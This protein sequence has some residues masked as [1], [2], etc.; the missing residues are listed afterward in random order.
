MLLFPFSYSQRAAHNLPLKAEVLSLCVY[1]IYQSLVWGSC[2]KIQFRIYILISQNV[3]TKLGSFSFFPYSYLTT[4]NIHDIFCYSW[5]ILH[6][7]HFNLI[8]TELSCI[9]VPKSRMVQ[10]W[11]ISVNLV[12]VKYVNT[13]DSIN[14]ASTAF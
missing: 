10:L 12:F 4:L 6:N 11:I 9:F 14:R 2:K 1:F 3:K 13:K 8:K 7:P 5:V